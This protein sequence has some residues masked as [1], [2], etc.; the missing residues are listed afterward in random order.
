MIY[1]SKAVIVWI[2]DHF[3]T[4]TFKDDIDKNAWHSLFGKIN[5]NLY[6]LLDININFL[7]TRKETE[8]FLSQPN[9]FLSNTYYYFIVDRK[10]P[11]DYGEDAI[12]SNS[13]DIIYDL[14]EYKKQ[15]NCLDFSVLSSGSADSYAIKN[16]DYYLKPQNREFTLPQELRHKILLNIKNNIGFI[17]QSKYTQSHQIKSF[18]IK[19]EQLSSTSM[20]YPFIDKF[21]SFVELQEI[22]KNDFETLIVL[23]D[24]S[25]SDKFI[26][27]SLRIALHDNF[28]DYDGMSY[29]VDKNYSA[30]KENGY[31]EDLL[32][33]TDK[34]SVIRFDEWST[35]SYKAMFKLF[36][37]RISV[38][39]INIDDDNISNYIDISNKTKVIKVDGLDS[40]NRD[41]A[42][43]I[44]FSLINKLTNDFSL[45]L[46]DS[47]YGENPI[48]FFHPITYRLIVDAKVHISELDDPSEIISEIYSYFK[49]LDLENNF[50]KQNI[51][52]SKPTEFNTEYI[53]TR[54]K[55]L[56]K[57]D[58][59]Y[60][61]I[62]TIKFWLKNS[63]NTN[64]N[65]K[66]DTSLNQGIWQEYSYK[67]LKE[68]F[69]EL[70]FSQLSCE[71]EI[72]FIQI[73][74]AINVFN[75]LSESKT[76][77]YQDISY[78]MV[79][80]HE[81]YPILFFMQNELSKNNNQKLYFQNTNFNFV[82]YAPELIQDYRLLENKI[83]YYR[84]IFELI[85][86]TKEYFPSSIHGTL[87]KI[88]F[89]IQ[90]KQ[91]TFQINE[92]EEFKKLANIFLRISIIFGESVIGK[93][94]EINEKDKAGLG[95][96]AGTYRDQVLNKKNHD[97]FQ[98]NH[99]NL[100]CEETNSEIDFVKEY[101]TVL[102]KKDVLYKA[103]SEESSSSIYDK[104]N[105]LKGFQTDDND[106][107]E[108][109]KRLLRADNIDLV[110]Q[111]STI[112]SS[113]LINEHNLKVMKYKDAYKLLA[114]LADTRNMW[115]HKHN[116]LWNNELFIRFFIYSFESIWLMQKFILQEIG[117]KD[118]PQTK[119]V[120]LNPSKE[121]TP[122]RFKT[123]EEYK[124]YFDKLYK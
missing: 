123:L 20:L 91:E 69:N 124:K 22:S 66:V 76:T 60:F 36:K 3:L 90:N 120:N 31:Y 5:S 6:R 83:D 65:V 73:N 80:P 51:M 99:L 63:W 53:Y 112:T 40:A 58:Y 116:E 52:D 21:R 57:E 100:I 122:T 17:D 96:L 11:Y 50:V 70:D 117:E 7:R 78:K 10:L 41:T 61:I 46:E 15:F 88:S 82:D 35:E 43:T 38:F 64:Y 39:V 89:R 95:T 12:D 37:Y 26:Q 45:Q 94:I 68:L 1:N 106:E 77:Q 54:C 84:D 97:L 44:L 24:K 62:N 101:G 113:L 28:K 72:D 107:N 8:E 48:L 27:Q 4:P 14:L 18:G 47:I 2:D 81:K 19:K 121:L 30:L 29:Y 114:Y 105:K 104:N 109:V 93:S 119:Y 92:N 49:K 108:Y 74:N 86:E 32:D 87:E 118:L 33:V 67:I 102:D 115:E 42:K 9:L 79:W 16:I 75:S 56:L 59:Q 111:L 98:I 25:I 23:V 110:S 34:I 103:L 55:Y 71:D 13:E 85:E